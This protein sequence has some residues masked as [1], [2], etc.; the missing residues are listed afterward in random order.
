VAL[1]LG[2]L[3]AAVQGWRQVVR[4]AIRPLGRLPVAEVLQVVVLA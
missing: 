3:L 2:L 4:A 1:G